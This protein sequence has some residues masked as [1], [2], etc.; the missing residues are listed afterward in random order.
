MALI[1]RLE[2]QFPTLEEVRC[3]VGIG[4]A[5][6]ADKAFIGRFDVLDVEEDRKLPLVTTKDIASGEV[7]WRG[8]G[9]INPFTDSG[10]LVR[11]QDYPRLRR[12]L[13][14]RRDVIG[15]RHCAQEDADQLVP[16]H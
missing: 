15:G 11:L 13:E 10:S 16:D 1:R 3:K 5:T 4:V 6:G 12:Y 8:Q 9:V 14:S 7:K 2:G